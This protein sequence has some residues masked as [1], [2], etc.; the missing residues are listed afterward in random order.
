MLLISLNVYLCLVQEFNI[1]NFQIAK[2][3]VTP[4]EF[5]RA[6]RVCTGSPLDGKL[7]ELT[8]KIFDEDGDGQLGHEEFMKVKQHSFAD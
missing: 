4:D 5:Q 8:F 3:P 6:V 1:L 2:K 7:I